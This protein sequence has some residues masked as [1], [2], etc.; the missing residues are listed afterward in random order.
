MPNSS[1]IAPSLSLYGHDARVWDCVLLDQF[2][3]S[4]GEVI[5]IC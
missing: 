4:S 1:S 3:L 5:H 2:I